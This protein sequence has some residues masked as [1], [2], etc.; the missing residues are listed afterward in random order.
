MYLHVDVEKVASK[1][2]KEASHFLATQY[3][4]VIR[5]GYGLDIGYQIQ[6]IIN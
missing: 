4:F 1:A 6:L 5:R 3:V 2:R